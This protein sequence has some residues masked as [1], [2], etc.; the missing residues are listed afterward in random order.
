MNSLKNK[1]VIESGKC[2]ISI[3]SG[4]KKSPDY[5]LQGYTHII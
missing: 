3:N 1:K 2:K 4:R 5:S